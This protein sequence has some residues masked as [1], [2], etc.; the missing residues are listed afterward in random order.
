MST[1][2]I[3]NVSSQ[4]T[5]V[6]LVENGV[7]AELYIE[8][9]TDRG[10]A[11]NIY[12]GKVVRVLPGMQA[13]FIDI[14]L[15][16][17]AFLYVS[18]VCSDLE[19]FEEMLTIEEP[20]IELDSSLFN[21]INRPLQIED[22]I[23]EGQ[24]VLVQVTKEPIGSKGARVSS[25]ITLPG[26]HL[27]L[28]PTVNH[29][30]VSRRIE[31]ENERKRL[32]EIIKKIKPD[33]YGFIVRTASE[34]KNEEDLNTDMDFLLKLWDNI[35]EKKNNIPIRSLIHHDLDMTMRTIRDLFTE[36]VDRLIIDSEK[37][38]KKTLEFVETFMPKMK[39]SV[40]L[41][42]KDEP[43]FDAYGIEV[44]IGRALGEKV[45]LKSGGYIVIEDTEAL[46]AIDVNTGKYVGRRNP[47]DTIL[48]TNLEAVKEIAYQLRLRN[49]GGIIIIDFIDM[50]KES[51]KEKVFQSLRQALKK[52]K[53]KTNILKI[54]ELGLVEMTR[55]RTRDSLGGVLCEPCTY[56]EGK[57]FIKSKTTILNEVIREI[58]REIT[59]IQGS[60]I[61][62]FVNPDISD[63][64]FEEERTEIDTLE[65]RYNKSIIIKARDDFHQEQFEVDGGEFMLDRV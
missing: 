4:E 9:H 26:R 18:D 40:E 35:L 28:M 27:V 31:N 53:A 64:L 29:L 41:Y 19:E 8:H 60:T 23:Y 12:K 65:R 2:L 46:V 25:H 30:G 52:D 54:S 57:G 6:A 59:E 32:R 17:A 45:W 15:E 38:Y 24:E 3:I 48:K 63:L 49:I 13:A 55:K 56:C 47:E 10:I 61:Y 7:L 11:G 14:G 39:Y 33:G 42:D 36:D 43:V 50:K 37:E 62:V 34:G 44:E 22:M 16:K 21:A 1:E 58:K 20:G 51:S 5:R